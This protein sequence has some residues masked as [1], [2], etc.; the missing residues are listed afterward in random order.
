M[1]KITS[2]PSVQ[3]DDVYNCIVAEQIDEIISVKNP[4]NCVGGIRVIIRYIV[5]RFAAP[6]EIHS[7]QCNFL[8]VISWSSTVS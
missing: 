3:A 7:S 8:S 6:Y 5:S 1:T 2:F 4:Q